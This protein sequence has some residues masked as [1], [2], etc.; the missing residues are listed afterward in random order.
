MENAITH[1]ESYRIAIPRNTLVVLCGPAGCGKSTFA[2]KHFLPT[3]TVSSDECRALVSDDPAN[4]SVSH[5]AFDLMY[6]IVEKRLLLGRFTTADA[7]N[8]QRED[9]KILIKI[10]RSFDLN[11]AAIVFDIPQEVC[12]ARNAA[13]ARRIPEEALRRQYELLEATLQTIDRE[14]FDYVYVL[15]RQGQDSAEVLVGPPKSPRRPR[16]R[17]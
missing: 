10:A 3:Q 1:P 15:D 5:H 16:R 7:T 6:F 17:Y 11:A 12:L 14:R 4:Q 13:R 2:A 9:R 8:L